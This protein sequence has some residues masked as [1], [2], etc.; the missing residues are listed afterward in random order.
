MSIH[1]ITY[2]LIALGAL[3]TGGL[4]EWIGAPGAVAL[5]AAVVISATGIVWI[6]QP[7]VRNIRGD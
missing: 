3:F 2:S 6:S 4:A 5:G 1:G 7:E